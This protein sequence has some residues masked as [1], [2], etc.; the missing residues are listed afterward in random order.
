MDSKTKNTA[1][2]V[3]KNTGLLYA[4]MGITMFISLYTTRLII[5]TLGVSDFGIFNLVGG[6]IAMLGFLN[7][8]MAG[9]TQ[10][11]MSYSEGEGNKEKQKSIFNISLALHIAISLLLVVVLLIAG[12]FFFNGIL[13][14][15]QDRMFAAKVVYYSLVVSTIFTVM[16]VP[17]DAVLNAH[18]NMLYYSIVGIIESILKLTVAL[19]VIQFSGD[20][21]M[22]YGVLIS[23][24]KLM[25]YGILM[26]VIPLITMTIMCIYCHRKYIECIIAPRKYWNKD[27]MKEMT[28]FAG[29][30]LMSASVNMVS[31]Y[32][33]GIILNNFFGTVL[34]TA[35]G[36]AGQINGQLQALSSNMLKALNPVIGKSAGADNIDALK[37]ATYLG[38]KYSTSLFMLIAIPVYFQ[39]PYL[40]KLWL[41][42]VPEW[43]VVFIRFQLI[44]T[45]IEFQF[46]TIPTAI[47]AK[48]K[49]KKITFW[50]SLFNILQLPTIY[51][52]FVNGFEP[53]YM[54]VVSIFLGNLVVYLIALHYAGIYCEITFKEY[55][56]NVTFPLYGMFF[57]MVG[58][59]Y[60]TSNLYTVDNIYSLIIYIA[61]SIILFF[62]IFF[63]IGNDKFERHLLKNYIVIIYSKIKSR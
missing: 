41:N 15:P 57:I 33:Q 14:I 6:A 16:S 39:T 58:I 32:G 3:I 12:Y 49:I 10:R 38:A 1:N 51:L 60:S 52:L 59:L 2:R 45:F 27:L 54:Y 44:K 8:A 43:T 5:N 50:A 7:A 36:I 29:C 4:K 26:A 48:G 28:G 22:L 56:L 40:L 17:Y 35:Q 30:N 53:Y 25:L 37:K 63:F 61:L 19:L 21:F 46:G 31:L 24:D 13:N 9:A 18:E 55:L 47:Y 11:F 62:L 20:K 34:N 23:C 42:E